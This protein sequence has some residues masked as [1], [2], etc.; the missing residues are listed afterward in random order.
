MNRVEQ[1]IA[2]WNEQAEKDAVRAVCDAGL[3]EYCMR[4]LKFP[5][6][7]YVLE[8][9]CGIGRLLFLTPVIEGVRYCGIDCSREMLF[10]VAQHELRKSKRKDIVMLQND[11]R[12]IPSYLDG[13]KV[14]YI[15]SIAVFQ[16]IDDEGVFDYLEEINRVLDDKGKF[17]LQFVVGE[18][19]TAF[20]WQRGI[21]ELGYMFLKA[22]LRIDEMEADDVMPNW[23]FVHGGVL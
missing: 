18:E 23:V 3:V 7:G 19:K 12:T 8:I 9:G 1:E 13:E 10:Y 14:M 15:Y 4:H 20:S 11:G 2:Y 22:G 21:G 6:S 16:H 5:E 17:T